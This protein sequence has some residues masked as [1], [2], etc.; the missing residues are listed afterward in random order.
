MYDPAAM[1]APPPQPVRGEGKPPFYAALNR[2]PYHQVMPELSQRGWSDCVAQPQLDAEAIRRV[3]AAYYGMVSLMDHHIGRIVEALRARGLLERTAIVFATDHGDYLGH[4]GLWGKGLPIYEDAHRLPFIVRLP[5]CATPGR[6]SAAVQSLVDIP[7]TFLALA[8]LSV[9]AGMQGLSQADAWREGRSAREAAILEFRPCDGDFMQWVICD[10]RWKLAL[11]DHRDYG[12]L[13]D[14]ES[15]PGCERNRFTDPSAAGERHR[16]S[17]RLERHAAPA[18][19]E[20]RPRPR[21]SG[22]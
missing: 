8:G 15:D 2:G 17:E 1:P 5:G 4:H 12:E 19:A 14:L 10:G 20:A 21:T 18:R 13:Y 3:Y 7:T 22:A 11:Y 6:R 9:P 16:L